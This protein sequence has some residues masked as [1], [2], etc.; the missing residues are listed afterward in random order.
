MEKR[1]ALGDAARDATEH[2]RAGA[3]TRPRHDAVQAP[4]VH[5]LKAH[6]DLVRLGGVVR[7]EEADDVGL[8]RAVAQSLELLNELPP[9]VSLKHRRG[10]QSAEAV[11]GDVH[12]AA[13]RPA[14][15]GADD[16]K[17]ADVRARDAVRELV[18]G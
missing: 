7:A 10:F 3:P 14:R 17:R 13:H 1:H 4:A 11:R 18:V 16:R 6:V 9:F 8:F 12:G 15:A 2:A 5:V